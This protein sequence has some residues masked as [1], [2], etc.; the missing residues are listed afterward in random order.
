MKFKQNGGVEIAEEKYDELKTIFDILIDKNDS[1]SRQEIVI[2]EKKLYDLVFDAKLMQTPNF[3]D[4][5]YLIPFNLDSI[6]IV[7]S[8]LCK[9]LMNNN[10]FETIT[11]KINNIINENNWQN[12]IDVKLNIFN[13]F[14]DFDCNENKN[15]QKSI[16]IYYL[17]LKSIFLFNK[18]KLANYIYMLFYVSYNII[19]SC[20]GDIKNLMR[21]FVSSIDVVHMYNSSEITRKLTTDELEELK[22][23]NNSSNAYT[24]M[25]TIDN[26]LNVLKMLYEKD[27]ISIKEY[28]RT[29]TKNPDVLKS[30]VNIID[31]I[32]G[33]FDSLTKN[34][35]SVDSINNFISKQ[36]GGKKP[37]KGGFVLSEAVMLLK[38]GS[39]IA[40]LINNYTKK[41][42]KFGNIYEHEELYTKIFKFIVGDENFNDFKFFEKKLENIRNKTHYIQNKKFGILQPEEINAIKEIKEIKE[43]ATIN[44]EQ[45]FILIKNKNNI[46]FSNEC[47]FENLTNL[48]K[49]IDIYNNIANEYVVKYNEIADLYSEIYVNKC[50]FDKLDFNKYKEEDSK[51]ENIENTENTENTQDTQDIANKKNLFEKINTLKLMCVNKGYDKQNKTKISKIFSDDL[52]ISKIPRDDREKFKQIYDEIV[53]LFNKIANCSNGYTTIVQQDFTIKQLLDYLYKIEQQQN[54]GVFCIRNRKPATATAATTTIAA[55]TAADKGGYRLIQKKRKTR[56]NRKNRKNRTIRKKTF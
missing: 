54:L 22:K 29:I 34:A 10:E 21:N 26:K 33:F 51:T 48:D 23:K 19:K 7:S 18:N 13:L 38:T 4:P 9:N 16:I 30:T 28:D 15:I 20:D 41:T 45:F 11:S 52:T 32:S 6:N 49:Y 1:V 44:I 36:K 46:T 40:S 8:N 35:Q 12:N 37:Q 47:S 17:V 25:N 42:Y 3:N 56:K 31:S 27:F 53:G 14:I 39:S 50:I 24:L 5:Y 43:L 2:N 55:T